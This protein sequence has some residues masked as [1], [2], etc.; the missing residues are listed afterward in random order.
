[1]RP[2]K[3]SIAL[4]SFSLNTSVRDVGRGNLRRREATRSEAR[5]GGAAPRGKT[6]ST[7]H[8]SPTAASERAEVR[9]PPMPTGS[10]QQC[11]TAS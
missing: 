7:R 5:A 6:G 8:R 3:L 2:T 11:V 9:S 10:W 1:M 4:H